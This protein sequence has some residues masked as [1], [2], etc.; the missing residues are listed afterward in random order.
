MYCHGIFVFMKL[1]IICMYVCHVCTSTIYIIYEYM[2]IVNKHNMFDYFKLSIIIIF[3]LLVLILMFMELVSLTL[4]LKNI[5]NSG[6][7][8]N[9]EIYCN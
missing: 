3:Q 2:N 5:L 4:V 8:Y 6:C 9:I 7:P 1:L